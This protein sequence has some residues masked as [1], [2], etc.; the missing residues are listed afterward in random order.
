MKIQ[1]YHT[2]TREGSSVIERADDGEFV[3]HSAHADKL[4]AMQARA[5]KAEAVVELAKKVN[6]FGAKWISPGA[7]N[8]GYHGNVSPIVGSDWNNFVAALDELS[9][10]HTL[11]G[12][13]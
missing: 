4:A 3:F 12:T 11:K 8:Y 1:R 13:T 5:E 10:S 2:F 7:D 6:A 9:T